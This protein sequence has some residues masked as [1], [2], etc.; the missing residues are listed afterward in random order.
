MPS[1]LAVLRGVVGVLYSW[2][3]NPAFDDAMHTSSTSGRHFSK[4]KTR[5]DN[6]G[7][8][9]L[10]RR[11]QATVGVVLA[12]IAAVGTFILANGNAQQQTFAV[13]S[14][15]LPAGTRLSA[16]D[17]DMVQLRATTPLADTAITD[18]S[19]AIGATL[20]GPV[21]R[22]ELFQ[23]GSLFQG[24][25]ESAP[26][27]ISFSLPASRALDGSLQ[28]GETV[29][30]LATDDN[31]STGV[32]RTVLSNAKILKISQVGDVVTVTLSLS[33]RSDGASVAGAI[34][35]GNVTLLRTTGLDPVATSQAAKGN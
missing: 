16:D 11:Q 12:A 27:Q 17:V 4:K 10:S 20:L 33:N 7:L 19:K 6:K 21:K 9:P 14:R 3:V 29:D 34:D 23:T 31:S 5:P 25:A 15:D 1:R 22:G 2:A 35:S 28:S 26:A 18:R 8:W 30:V 24:P 32:A 13:A